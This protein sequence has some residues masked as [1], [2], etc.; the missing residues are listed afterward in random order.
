[1]IMDTENK[2][3]LKAEKITTIITDLDETL[4]QGVL[5][6]KQKLKPNKDYYEFLKSVYRRG[7]QIFVVSKN[8]E[9]DVLKTFK[10][11]G[12][13]K[14]FFTSILVNWDPKYLNIERLLRQTNIR[15]ET[16]IFIDDGPLERTEVK[17]KIES[18]HCLDFREW[19]ILQERRYLKHKELQEES[20]IKERINRYR[21]AIKAHQ[22][23]GEIKEDKE[24]LRKLKRE[25]SIGEISFENM[26]R[27]TRLL[28]VTH[29]IN[30]NPEKFKDYD[31]T[32]DYLY[33]KVSEGYKLFAI[34]TKESGISL[35]LTGALVVKIEGKKAIVEDGTFSCG[36]IGR[37]FEQKSLLA[38]CD[39]L[40]K[41]GIEEISF[42]VKLTSTN[43]RVREIFE[44][45][46]I[47]E[48]ERR[49][50]D[51]LYTTSLEG[52]TPKKTYDWIKILD[53]PPEMDYY[54]IPSIIEFFDKNV[55]PRIKRSFNIVN[56]GSAKGEV[57]GHLKED[58]K[59]EFCNFIKENNIGYTKV[60]IEKVPE[61]NNI[62]ANAEDLSKVMGNE[63]QDLV[64]AIELLE[65]TE[66]FW[67]VI[68][69]MI[70]I[71]K[72]RG[73]IFITVPNFHYPKHEY[74]IDLWRIGPKTLSSFFPKDS[75]ELIKIE[76]EGDRNSPRRTMI[77]V[78]KIKKISTNYKIPKNGKTDWKSG[79]TI[80]P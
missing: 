67:E 4:W 41:Q 58:L 40:K 68:N 47:N 74:P 64:M 66:H 18:I 63:T 76:K 79:L 29:R 15:P 43:K 46:G 32:L 54:G 38:F 14:N 73:Y 52:L 1:M 23:R 39:I 16:T 17:T 12:I 45:L 61:E 60:D 56:L 36:I 5:A 2:R 75:F 35:G 33:K 22:L 3:L 30:F 57:L 28:V 69:E 42:L 48:K 26:D 55:K 72:T 31:K 59:K 50:E 11:L 7:I 25:L 34:S 37:D 13:D 65:H 78:N 62:V 70:R 80:F 49:A 20:E 27:F 21:T 10:E 9:N 19:K 53:T 8:D 77:F 71:C 6:E 51:I 44:E 24:F